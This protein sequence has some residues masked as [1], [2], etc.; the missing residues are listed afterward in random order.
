MAY[1]EAIRR[2]GVKTRTICASIRKSYSQR[3]FYSM[4]IELYEKIDNGEPG[5]G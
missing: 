5:Q 2:G 1:A 4:M 3:Q